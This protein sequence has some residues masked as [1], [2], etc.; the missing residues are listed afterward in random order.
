MYNGQNPIDGS[1]ALAG[2]GGVANLISQATAG[3][4]ILAPFNAGDVVTLYAKAIGDP[5]S[6]AS[7]LSNADGRTTIAAQWVSAV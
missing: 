5:A 3:Q 2:A 1:Q 6:N 7:I 4:T